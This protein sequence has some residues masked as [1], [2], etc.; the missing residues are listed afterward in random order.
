MS[1]ASGTKPGAKARENSN[2][3]SAKGASPEPRPRIGGKMAKGD[4]RSK[5][6]T[7]GMQGS[8]RGREC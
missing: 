6:M 8:N 1:N 2:Y 3:T 7:G 5:S 4:S